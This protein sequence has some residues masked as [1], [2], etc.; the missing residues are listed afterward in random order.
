V[1]PQRSTNITQANVDPDTVVGAYC[2][3]GLPFTPKNVMV[4]GQAVFD[5]GQTDLIVTSFVNPLGVTAGD[6]AG[7][8]LVRVFDVSA[9]ALA[10][11]AFH[12][13]FED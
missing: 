3:T 6:C 12:I 1:I 13:W 9:G 5:G 10:D 4:S 2:F 7:T 11:G 8:V